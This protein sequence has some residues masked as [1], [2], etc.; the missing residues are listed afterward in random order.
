MAPLVAPDPELGAAG[1]GPIV[2]IGLAALRPRAGAMAG[3]GWLLT[4]GLVAALAGLL[5]GGARLHGIDAGALRAHPG[6]H[7]A[8]DGFVAAVPRRNG[9]E[10]DVRVD[11]PAGRVLVVAP[12][13]VGDLPVGSGGHAAGGLQQPKPERGGGRRGG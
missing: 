13:P 5:V 7:V 6:Q 3:L 11:S 10:V 2:V 8:V 12:E 9:D 1:V 4:V